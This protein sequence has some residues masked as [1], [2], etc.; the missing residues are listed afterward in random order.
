[1]LIDIL[2]RRGRRSYID[3]ATHPDVF[4]ATSPFNTAKYR[5]PGNV[6]QI[7]APIT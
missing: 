6:H 2:S 7:Q 4:A 3:F 5:A 1:M